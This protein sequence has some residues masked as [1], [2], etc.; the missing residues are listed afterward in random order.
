MNGNYNEIL[1]SLQKT[2]ADGGFST[3]VSSQHRN[4]LRI[5]MPNFNCEQKRKKKSRKKS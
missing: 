5:G 4:I 3:E 2:I 1:K